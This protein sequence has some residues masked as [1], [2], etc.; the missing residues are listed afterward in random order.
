MKQNVWFFKKFSSIQD[1]N[2]AK[3]RQHISGKHIGTQNKS[4]KRYF[5]GGS[6]LADNQEIFGLFKKRSE[7]T[8]LF[9]S[10]FL[11][12]IISML[13][14]SFILFYLTIDNTKKTIINDSIN[15]I[16]YAKS[17]FEMRINECHVVANAISGNILI[18]EKN[19]TN[20]P[21]G[22]IIGI[23]ELQKYKLSNDNFVGIGIIYKETSPDKLYASF[24]YSRLSVF[25]KDN[26]KMTNAQNNIIQENILN[27]D[28]PL[29]MFAPQANYIIYSLPIRFANREIGSKDVILF[30]MNANILDSF[31]DS[32]QSNFDTVSCLSD[33]KGTILFSTG[34]IEPE[35]MDILKKSIHENLLEEELYIEN[36]GAHINMTYLNIGISALYLITVIPEAQFNQSLTTNVL[37]LL[38]A[39]F[40]IT[41]ICLGIA[42]FLS[43]KHFK[44]LR[45]LN[46]ILREKECISQE[47][48]SNEL[49]SIYNAM[50]NMIEANENL[51]N[52]ITTN[53]NMVRESFI[54]RLFFGDFSSKTEVFREADSSAV[55]LSGPR[56][57]VI[58]L[59]ERKKNLQIDPFNEVSYAEL[60]RHHFGYLLKM[61]NY[62]AVLL[63][64]SKKD[65]SVEIKLT[66]DSL[67]NLLAFELNQDIQI[68]VGAISDDVLRIKDSFSQACSALD[69]CINSQKEIVY[70]NDIASGNNSEEILTLYLKENAFL[71]N[72]LLIGDTEV[73]Q[74]KLLSLLNMIRGRNYHSIL[75]QHICY[76]LVEILQQT[77]QKI[78][79]YSTHDKNTFDQINTRIL[80]LAHM[81]R[82]EDFNRYSQY[83]VKQICQLA[84]SNNKAENDLERSVL[85]YV[86]KNYNNV[87]LSLELLVD[88]FGNTYGYWSRFFSEKIGILFSE[89]IWKLRFAAAKSMLTE[90]DIPIKQIVKKIGYSD[91]ASFNRKFKIFTGITPGQFRKYKVS[92]KWLGNDLTPSY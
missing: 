78:S 70:F 34:T 51:K 1:I 16:Q 90:S 28:K 63:N 3:I 15:K 48:C 2:G 76:Q 13:L 27:S 31:F 47:S 41:G 50:Q 80:T 25:L 83:V 11:I 66:V 62:C 21:E 49:F 53:M 45:N 5:V 8:R 17:V 4:N 6:A 9:A 91:Q 22:T 30:I 52:Q 26:C 46:T 18:S 72:V 12:I 85:A 35:I 7:S 56:F 77:V 82:F 58:L 81:Q 57:C 14:M 36:H 71:A 75:V 69:F 68:G 20:S 43:F 10:F 59:C 40:T 67:R 74:S 24:G 61:E 32:R 84:Q 73:A 79:E 33:D 92:E 42:K 37:L 55:R 23:K 86:R 38:A 60:Q 19:I 29:L 89:Y 64:I 87:N 88:H 65:F 44:V 54:C 39:T